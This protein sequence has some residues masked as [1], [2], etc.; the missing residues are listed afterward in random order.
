MSRRGRAW[1][2]APSGRGKS[3]ATNA[4]EPAEKREL[5]PSCVEWNPRPD[6]R[7]KVHDPKRPLRLDDA[8]LESADLIEPVAGGVL[9]WLE[10]HELQEVVSGEVPGRQ[11]DDDVVVFKSN[12]LAA[13]DV[14]IAAAAVERARAADAGREVS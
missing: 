2:G 6:I 11:S 1:A 8:K 4:C 7:R 9:D 10:V 5:V 12:G 13:W 14:A 3:T